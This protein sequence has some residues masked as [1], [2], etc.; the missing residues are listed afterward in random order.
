[1]QTKS[2]ETCQYD[3]ISLGEVMLRLD[4]G[5][6]ASTPPVLSAHGKAAANTTW[7][8]DSAAVSANAP[9]W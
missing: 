6:D 2:P 4:P 3:I 9:A 1:M 7:H 5:E 8:A